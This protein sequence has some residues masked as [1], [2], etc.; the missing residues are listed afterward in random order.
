MLSTD[1]QTDK[2]TSATK[3]ITSFAKEVIME[4]GMTLSC[5]EFRFVLCST[6]LRLE[7]PYPNV[8]QF[9]T[10]WI[11]LASCFMFTGMFPQPNSI[12]SPLTSFH[13]ILSFCS[14]FINYGT[15]AIHSRQKIIH[16][17]K[18]KKLSKLMISFSLLCGIGAEL[19]QSRT[20]LYCFLYKNIKG[21][22]Q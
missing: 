11:Y 15:K 3:N 14:S 8:S 6:C 12:V 13:G 22:G 1:R 18:K 2:Q 4:K 20:C 7:S 16:F 5:L 21:V 19:I 9:N 17:F 10:P